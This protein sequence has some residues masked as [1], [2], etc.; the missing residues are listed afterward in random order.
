MDMAKMSSED[1]NLVFE[2][3]SNMNRAGDKIEYNCTKV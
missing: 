2:K 1:R 3:T